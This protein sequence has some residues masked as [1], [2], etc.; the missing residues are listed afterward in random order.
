[1]Y[2][3][4]STTTKQCDLYKALKCNITGITSSSGIGAMGYYNGAEIIKIVL[5]TTEAV[6]RK[7]GDTTSFSVCCTSA[8]NIASSGFLN[9]TY[10]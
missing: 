2:V 1:M 9:V 4:W 3:N 5:T 7:M 10:A 6:F 8:A